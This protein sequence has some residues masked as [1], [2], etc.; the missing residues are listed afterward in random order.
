MSAPVPIRPASLE[1]ILVELQALRSEVGQLR[2]S[3]RPGMYEFP[4]RIPRAVVQPEKYTS[5][6]PAAVLMTV[7]RYAE[8]RGK[9][10]INVIMSEA[11]RSYIPPEHFEAV[12]EELR[13]EQQRLWTEQATLEERRG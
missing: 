1:A 6:L 9:E 2:Q 4:E 12:L 5:T 13:L 10:N 11:L 8:F 7:R 3:R